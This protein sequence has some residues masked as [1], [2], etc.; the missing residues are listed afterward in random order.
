MDSKVVIEFSDGISETVEHAEFIATRN[1]VDIADLLVL[2][3]FPAFLRH[4]PEPAWNIQRALEL[5]G[6]FQARANA[7]CFDAWSEPS[8]SQV[9]R[10]SATVECEWT[11][12]RLA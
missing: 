8:I 1:H 2:G 5:S 12:P 4:D 7:F 6:D 10:S 9:G 3:R 11:W